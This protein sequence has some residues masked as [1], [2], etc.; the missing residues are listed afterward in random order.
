MSKLSTGAQEELVRAVRVRYQSAAAEEKSH[1]LDEFVAIT[2]Y[3]RKNALR[4]FN[5]RRQV[6]PSKKRGRIEAV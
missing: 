1:I 3:H 5:G 2:G 4:L 6:A